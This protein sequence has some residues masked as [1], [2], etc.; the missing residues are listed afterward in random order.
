MWLNF[1]M[2]LTGLISPVSF[3]YVK[4]DSVDAARNAIGAMH[5]QVYEGRRLALNFAQSNFPST[6]TSPGETSVPTRTIYVGNIPFEMTDRELNDMFKDMY[7]LIDVRVAVDRRTGQP[8]GFCHAEF[9]DVDSAKA[10]FEKLS[11]MAPYGRKLR[12][13]YSQSAP[14]RLQ[15]Y[16][17]EKEGT[18]GSS[19][20][21]AAVGAAAAIPTLAPEQRVWRSP[22]LEAQEQAQA[23]EVT[24]AQTDAAES[25]DAYSEA[26]GE[27]TEAETTGESQEGQ[28]QGEKETSSW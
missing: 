23:Q 2:K 6:S 3:G 18:A 17:A 16:L 22:E 21:L 24:Q 20:G 28:S 9:V 26:L 7:N 27:A 8:R 11:Q 1:W 13:D 10:A 14:G 25:A 5:M 15:R 12:M 4:F 19:D